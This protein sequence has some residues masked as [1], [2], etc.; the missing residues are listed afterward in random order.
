MMKCVKRS[1]RNNARR[2][3]RKLQLIMMKTEEE[4]ADGLRME[5]P[6]SQPSPPPQS[7]SIP[8]LAAPSE[9]C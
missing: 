2:G 9:C 4:E 8:L 1:Y 6:I 3:R 7:A 5:A